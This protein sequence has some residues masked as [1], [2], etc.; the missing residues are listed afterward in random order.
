MTTDLILKDGT[1]FWSKFDMLWRHEIFLET[2]SVLYG[3]E[4]FP[5]YCCIIFF[6]QKSVPWTYLAEFYFNSNLQRPYTGT[7]SSCKKRLTSFFSCLM[8]MRLLHDPIMTN[9][10]QSPLEYSNLP[11]ALAL[12][13]LQSRGFTP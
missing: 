1:Q 3:Q 7:C 4:S 5:E 2:K 12:H 13:A 11:T 9:L 6:S 10:C 8:L